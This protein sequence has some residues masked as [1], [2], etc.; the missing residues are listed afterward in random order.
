MYGILLAYSFVLGV[1]SYAVFRREVWLLILFYLFFEIG[2]VITYDYFRI[3]WSMPRRVGFISMYFLGYFSL[4]ILYGE[5]LLYD[6]FVVDN[7]W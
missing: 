4:F 7:I 6:D 1:L 2:I 3:R 5:R